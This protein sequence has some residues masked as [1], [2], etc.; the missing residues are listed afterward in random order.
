[1]LQNSIRASYWRSTPREFKSP[2]RR[3]YYEY[4]NIP[5]AQQWVP[6]DLDDVVAVL[7]L[8]TVLTADGGKEGERI[9]RGEIDVLCLQPT[10]ERKE[11]SSGGGGGLINT[12]S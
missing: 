2:P 10:V 12:A 4:Q 5:L 8:P 3:F 9:Q 1:M 7:T 6:V 11:G